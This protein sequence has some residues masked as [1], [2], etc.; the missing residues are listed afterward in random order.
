MS[1]GP[2]FGI[3]SF[4]IEGFR[5]IKNTSVEGIPADTKWFF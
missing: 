4:H 2:S 3:T 1:N 5:G